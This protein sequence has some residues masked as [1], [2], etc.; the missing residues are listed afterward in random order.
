[1]SRKGRGE[2]VVFLKRSLKTRWYQVTCSLQA[3]LEQQLAVEKSKMET[4][5]KRFQSAM[6][7]KVSLLRI[8]AVSMD[9]GVWFDRSVKNSSKWS[10]AFA[11]YSF[12]E[13]KRRQKQQQNN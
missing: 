12:Y 1:M 5:K 2:E 11:L 6:N 13:N 8:D 4:E 10:I 7:E 3:L 9:R